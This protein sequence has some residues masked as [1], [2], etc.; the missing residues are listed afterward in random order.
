[1][2]I[3]EKK[4]ITTREAEILN[5]SRQYV[6]KLIKAG[7]LNAVKVGPY[8]RLSGGEVRRYKDVHR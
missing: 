1:M 7:E 4:M 3:D 2:R 6:V 5:V 8:R